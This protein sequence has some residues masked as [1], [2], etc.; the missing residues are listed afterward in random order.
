MCKNIMKPITLYTK[1]KL[2]MKQRKQVVYL[3]VVNAQIHEAAHL[4]GNKMVFSH[5]NQ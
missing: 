3:N 2:I 4:I 5:L 1:L